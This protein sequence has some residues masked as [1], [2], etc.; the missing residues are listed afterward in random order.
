MMPADPSVDLI[1]QA[2]LLVAFVLAA[3]HLHAVHPQVGRQQTGPIGILGVDKRQRDKCATIIGPG[4]ELRKL[5]DGRLIPENR[6]TGH[7]TWPHEPQSERCITIAPGMPPEVP[8]I[9]L[10]F[11]QPPDSVEGVAEQK[12]GAVEGAEQ[13]AGHGKPAAFDSGEV[14]RR[15]ARFVHSALDLGRFQE[16][17]DFAVD[18]DELPRPFQIGQAGFQVLIAHRVICTKRSRGRERGRGRT[19][20]DGHYTS[21]GQNVRTAAEIG[22]S[23]NRWANGPRG[24]AQP[25]QPAVGARLS[26]D[27][28][29][30]S[31]FR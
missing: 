17:I 2:D 31:H 3:R 11:D 25:D 28:E 5:I 13:V 26:D 7:L 9:D 10:E 16:R 20:A 15:S 6:P 19:G 18:P 8:G 4:L 14:Q 22:P 12:P 24:D 29:I 30:I 1:V 21:F 27:A 23:L